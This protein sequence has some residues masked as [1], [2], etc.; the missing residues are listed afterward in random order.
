MGAPGGYQ[1]QE[2]PR[3]RGS[4]RTPL[5]SCAASATPKPSEPVHFGVFFFLMEVPLGII[6]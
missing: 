3:P 2:G 4:G 1:E 5:P 6:G